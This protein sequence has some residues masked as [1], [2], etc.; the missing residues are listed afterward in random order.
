[1]EKKKEIKVQYVGFWNGF[2]FNKSRIHQILEKNYNVIISDKPDYVFC[3]IFNNEFLKYEDAIRIFY[4]GE[5]ITPDFNLYDYA[6]AFDQIQFGDRYFRLPNYLANLKYE[7]DLKNVNN[8]RNSNYLDDKRKFCCIVCSN[9]NADKMRQTIVDEI[10]KYKIVDSGGRYRNNIGHPNGV[11]NKLEFQRNYKFVLALEN[12]S[13]NGYITEKIVEAFAAGGIPIYW[14]APDIEKYFNP[15]AFINAM[16][17]S[18]IDALVDRIKEIDENDDL[19]N[20]YI[21]EMPMQKNYFWDTEFSQLEKF[22]CNI[23]EQ[24]LNKARRRQNCSWTKKIENMILLS[25]KGKKETVW[26]KIKKKT[27]KIV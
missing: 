12:A 9:G 14:G 5:N 7:E 4:C 8:R 19:Y 1:M 13:F 16:S 22:I 26:G 10:S 25:D 27:K 6:I 15:K 2:D 21:S 20:E 23:I 18:S 24:P 11:D 17:F 3:S